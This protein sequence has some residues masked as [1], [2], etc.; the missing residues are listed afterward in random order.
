MSSFKRKIHLRLQYSY[1]G[2]ALSLTLDYE[3]LK[4]CDQMVNVD[5]NL[6]QEFI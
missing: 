3:G 2:N 1:F 4:K 6:A 5:G